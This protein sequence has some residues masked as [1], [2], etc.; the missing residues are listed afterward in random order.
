MTIIAKLLRSTEEYSMNYFYSDFMGDL[1]GIVE[2][3]FVFKSE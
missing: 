2:K 1:M 3:L